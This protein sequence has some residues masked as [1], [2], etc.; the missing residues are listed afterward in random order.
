MTTLPQPHVSAESSTENGVERITVKVSR[1]GKERSWSG[2]STTTAGAARELV[3][4]ILSDHHTAEY[5]KKG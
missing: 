1:D 3:E 4:N 5:V 2:A